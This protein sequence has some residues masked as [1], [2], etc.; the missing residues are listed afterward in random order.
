MKILIATQCFP[1]DLGG[2]EHVM[3]NIAI[4][5][6]K[7]KNEVFVVSDKSKHPSN[8]FDKKNNYTISRFGQIKYF[9]KFKKANYINKLLAAQ[10]FDLIF[11]DSWKSL[12][13]IDDKYQSERF[14][15]LVHGNE[16]LKDKN[17]EK[18]VKNISKTNTII[19]NSLSTETLF[20]NI[21]TNFKIKK[22]KVIYP[23]FIANIQKPNIKKKKYDFCTIG[24]LER[25]K[26]HQLIL[27]A[28]K[29]LK[30][31]DNILC[32]YAILGEGEELSRLKNYVL[33]YSL[34]NQVHFFSGNERDKVLEESKIHVMPT[35]LDGNSIEGFGISNVE[36]S[37]F[38]L[39]C[40][41]SSSGGTQESI[42]KNQTGLVI[43]EKN[44]DQLY[45]AMKDL[46]QDKEK[47]NS[48]SA[49]SLKFALNFI[50]ENKI[51]EY[52]NAL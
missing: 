22:S 34:Q 51:I 13:Y 50:K 36:A 6:S 7:A 45:I 19:F 3:G 18:V 48:F 46:I 24:R 17:K 30:D 9:R 15:C 8:E 10:N 33:K 39:P 43:E 28:L 38:G 42:I 20:K 37:S 47:Y 52:L 32:N 31:I 23:A 49:E 27:E 14:I 2:I 21:F 11:F 35:F 4:E 5:A 12:E 1:P 29:T 40:I 44:I 26:G 25:R 41:V 16:I